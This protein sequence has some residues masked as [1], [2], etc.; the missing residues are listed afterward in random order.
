MTDAGARVLHELRPR[1]H[2]VLVKM[3]EGKSNRDIAMELNLSIQYV[4][5]LVFCIFEKTGASTRMELAIFSF[6]HGIVDCPCSNP[7]V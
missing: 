3:C 4:K 5:N 2:A 6:H 7:K 1:E